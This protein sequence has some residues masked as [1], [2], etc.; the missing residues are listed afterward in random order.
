MNGEKNL[1]VRPYFYMGEAEQFAFYRIP[2]AFF[3]DPALQDISADA[4]ILYGL[5]LDRLIL[6]SRNGWVDEDGRVFIYYTVQSIMEDLKCGNKKAA[7]LM[8]ELES[9]YGLIERKK[10]GQG[11]PARI[12][13]KNFLAVVTP[14]SSTRL[15][16]DLSTNHG[17][18]FPDVSE[19]NFQTCQNDT[20]RD[21]KSTRQD[22]S[23][24]H[25]NKNNKNNNKM[26][27][28][29]L[30][31]P[32]ED[33]GMDMD[34]SYQAYR[35]YFCDSLEFDILL[36]SHPYEQDMLHEILELLVE[37]VTVQKPY[38]RISGDEK[39]AQVVKSRLMKLEYGHI[40]YVLGCMK[41]NTTKV[42]N[43]K[44]YLLAALYNAPV[45]MSNYYSA[46][47]NHDLYGGG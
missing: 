15:S 29:N 16:T 3:T 10:Q 43:I 30:I 33:D 20:S 44:Q 19:G 35:D 2:K 27:N 12:Y 31:Y 14:A 47:V 26:S 9:G 46:L 34:T 17:G 18:S 39:P 5:M 8:Q 36:K 24:G 13:V 42:R 23:K 1:P 4:K 22:V 7:K 11:K 41:E 28:T 25:R 37:T 21:V 45:T 40:E 38:I 32:D 6:S